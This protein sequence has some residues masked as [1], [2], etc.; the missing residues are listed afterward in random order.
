MDLNDI[1][2]KTLILVQTDPNRDVIFNA[3]KKSGLNADVIFK[4]KQ[5]I[6]RLLRRLWANH[7]SLVIHYGL[8][9]GKTIYI[10]TKLLLFMLI[11]EQEQYLNLYIK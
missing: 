5:K 3:W 8:E 7:F 9:I 6:I 4:P 11:L 10:G 2:N 1:K